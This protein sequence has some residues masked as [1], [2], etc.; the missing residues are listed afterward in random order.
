MHLWD[1]GYL[2]SI[3]K[4]S[5]NSKRSL[6][7]EDSRMSWSHSCFC[8]KTE[9]LW[10]SLLPHHHLCRWQS[11]TSIPAVKYELY[12]QIQFELWNLEIS[13]FQTIPR[14]VF[15]W[16]ATLLKGS[17]AA[18]Q[19]KEAKHSC[20]LE[21]FSGNTEHWNTIGWTVL[22]LLIHRLI[23]LWVKTTCFEK[24]IIVT[25]ISQISTTLNSISRTFLMFNSYNSL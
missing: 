9:T 15:R 6:H 4:T 24:A 25:R 22:L 21:H 7:N 10:N 19:Y 5:S 23:V 14:G 8:W 12:K 17:I 1:C 18:M 13:N 20:S 2:M 16:T 11:T 3:Y